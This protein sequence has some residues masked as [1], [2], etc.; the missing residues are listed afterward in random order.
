[1][2]KILAATDFSETATQA[3]MQAMRIARHVG[4]DLILAHSDSLLSDFPSFATEVLGNEALRIDMPSVLASK[5]RQL[6]E[7][8][9]RLLGQGAEV[10][11]VLADAPPE[12]GICRAADE[13]GVDLVVVGSHGRTGMRRL[14]LGSVAAKIARACS[15]SVLVARGEAGAGG[16]RRILVPVDFSPISERQMDLARQLAAPGAQ[17]LL[18][19]SWLVPSVLYGPFPES[20]LAI[21]PLVE[22]LERE[23]ERRGQ[24]L[25]QKYRSPIAEVSFAKVCA[26]AAA[27]IQ[28]ALEESGPF[29]LVITGSRSL[30]GAKRW[31][32]GST[33]ETTIRHSPCSVLVARE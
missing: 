3:V 25:V 8:R 1:M 15:K 31:L 17:V 20:S 18:L 13:F 30:H 9:Q 33:A 28:S 7:L 27:G 26:S 29:D 2:K 16:Y 10:T 32:L 21:G 22:A 4:A 24:Q 11:Q 12:E 5:H 14:L 19:H 23:G 6:E